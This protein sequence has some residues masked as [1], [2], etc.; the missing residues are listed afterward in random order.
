MADP[1]AVLQAMQLL[2]PDAPDNGWNEIRVGADL[3]AGLTPNAIALA[4]WKSRMAQTA[5]L[6]DISE[7]GSTRSISQAWQHAQAM[8]TFY[9]Q[10]VQLETPVDN[11]RGNL[12]S[13]TMKRV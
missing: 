3:D 2:G 13:F 8:V 12:R 5:T 6:I 9:Q 4:W 1:N 10:Q 11:P 7:G